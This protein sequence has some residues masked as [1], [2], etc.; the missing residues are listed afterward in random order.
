MSEVEVPIVKLAKAQA[1]GVTFELHT[2]GWEAYQGL[3]GCVLGEV[4]GQ[5][6]TVFSGSNDAGQDGAFQGTWKTKSEE[7]YTGRFVV[8]CKFTC[9]RDYN[10]S[11]SDLGDELDKAKRLAAAGNAQVYLLMTNAKLSGASETKIRAAFAAISG[12]DYFDI[13]GDEWLTEE[14]RKSRRLR[15]LV[16]RL[17]GL[18]DLSQ[19]LD[20]RVYR[21]ANELLQSWK[22]NLA[23]F[24]PTEAHRKSVEALQSK[25]FV[26]LLGDPMAG[27]STISAALALAAADIWGCAPIFVTNAGDLKKNWNP[28]EPDQFFWVD[29]VFGQIQYEGD[30]AKAWNRV[31]PLLDSALKAGARVVFTSRTNIFKAAT[32]DLKSSSFPLLSNS[33]VVVEV[34]KLSL[35]EKQRILYNHLKMGEQAAEFRTKIKPFLNVVAEHPKFLPEIARR[36]GNPMFTEHVYL[37]E[38]HLSQFVEKPTQLL[39]DIIKELGRADFA[40]LALLFMRSGK[41]EKPLVLDEKET[42]SLSVINANQASIRDSLVSLE[43]VLVKTS[44]DRDG[45]SWKFSHPTI[46]EAMASVISDQDDLLDIYLVGAKGSEIVNE[47]ACGVADA[48]WAKIFVP[49]SR[50]RDVLGKLNAVSLENS[51]QLYHVYRFL[52]KHCSDEFLKLWAQESQDSYQRVLC[53]CRYPASDSQFCLVLSRL[54]DID[55]L[56]EAVR[57]T[58]LKS[59]RTQLKEELDPT[60]LDED[61]SNL[62]TDE[63]RE[64]IMGFVKDE[65]FPAAAGVIE[66][67]EYNFDPENDDPDDYLSELDRRLEGFNEV[68]YGH[69]DVETFVDDTIEEIVQAKSRLKAKADE[70]PEFDWEGSESMPSSARDVGST[71]SRSIFDDVDQ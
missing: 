56:D 19:I 25:G 2:L 37:S 42:T 36:L 69:S 52:G 48:L 23:K 14:I 64:E 34:E 3:C 17:Y 43:G 68:F 6:Y 54:R 32:R 22:D 47:C 57:Q 12:V 63:E 61:L 50:Y 62:M 27:K 24:V 71:N 58:F 16:P 70:V 1:S 8:Q 4:L 53:S 28:D 39:I 13:L 33:Q 26:M 67:Y 38:G 31:F 65:V 49:E 15:A 7:N 9:K 66:E 20:E 51:W 45:A 59:L 40:A 44:R 5:T 60:G 18:G 41:V 30:L 11:L 55:L 35:S 21:Q 10:I 46:R 29:D